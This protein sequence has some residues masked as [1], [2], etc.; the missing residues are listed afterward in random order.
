MHT[1]LN[2]SAGHVHFF[3]LNDIFHVILEV[4]MCNTRIEMQKIAVSS[5][6]IEVNRFSSLHYQKK[7]KA[8][9]TALE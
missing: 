7:Q 4:S 6:K 2:L 5:A 8:N 3:S 1:L 9:D